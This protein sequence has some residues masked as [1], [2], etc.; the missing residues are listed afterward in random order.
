MGKMAGLI[1]EWS[2]EEGYAYSETEPQ[3]DRSEPIR[4]GFNSQQRSFGEEQGMEDLS[5]VSEIHERD[6]VL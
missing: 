6:L 5:Q 4:R 3:S 1:D 2:S